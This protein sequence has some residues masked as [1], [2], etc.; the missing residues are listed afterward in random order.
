MDRRSP[1]HPAALAAAVGLATFVSYLLTQS[2]GL[3]YTDSGEL[4]AACATLGVAHPTGYPLFTLLGHTWTLLPWSSVIGGLNVLAAVF[5]SASVSMLFFVML[6][7]RVSRY[8]AMS[9]ALLYGWTSIV[10][11]QAQS[12]EVYSLHALLLT[13]TLYAA[14]RSRNAAKNDVRWFAITA[15]FFGLMLTNHLSS[16]FLLPGI[17]V[18]A[19]PSGTTRAQWKRLALIACIGLIPLA[20]YAYL[21]LRSSQEPL[22][23][24]GMV[25]RSLDAFLYHVKGTQF[26]VWLFSD[27]KVAGKNL[28]VFLAMLP[29]AVAWIGLIAIAIGG[30]A[31]VRRERRTALALALILGGNLGISLG[32]SIPDIENYFLPSVI[33]AIMCCGVG[34]HALLQRF[35]AER[36]AFALLLLPMVSAT[37]VWKEQNRSHDRAVEAYT[38]LILDNAAPNAMIITHQ[39]DYFCSAFWYLQT[40][41]GVRPDVTII[42]KEL[43]RRTWYVPYLSYRYPAAMAGA[44]SA[45]AAYAPYLQ[46]FENNSDEFM[47]DHAAVMAIQQRFV[48]LLNAILQS[49]DGKRPVYI[50][51]EMVNEEQ[52]FATDH[53]MV[54]AGP[55]IRLVRDSITMPPFNLS[56]VSEIAASLKGHNQRLD[57]GL[58]EI[59]V[60]SLAQ[61]ARYAWQVEHNASAF[62]QLR[63]AVRMMDP[64]SIA[65]RQLDEV[66]I[67]TP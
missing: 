65:I 31:L 54:P 45:A 35:N 11:T 40:V 66:H 10:W 27:D 30:V 25:H 19:L 15:L 56:R 55:L 29:Q 12:I 42:D 38:R 50:T 49:N 64:R 21:P 63:E 58:R 17:V 18:L 32:Y 36:F 34:F 61:A 57:K 41:E 1:L 39:W 7:L 51:G 26:G 13:T 43:L 14:L 2:P 59:V 46:M 52:G 20:L 60:V 48:A 67:D 5:V 4:A 8:V 44:Q 22:V 33:M 47:K 62:K 3:S 37:S 16:A 23:N 53:R 6:E 28:K 24:W 9:V